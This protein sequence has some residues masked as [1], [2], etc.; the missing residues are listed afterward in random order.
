MKSKMKFGIILCLVFLISNTYSQHV[1]IELSK[2]AGNKSY[3]T[4][5]VG[6]DASGNIY[7]QSRRIHFGKMSLWGKSLTNRGQGIIK[8]VNLDKLS[9][10]PRDHTFLQLI[11]EGP[12]PILVFINELSNELVAYRTN[13]KFELLGSPFVIGDNNEC[14][15]FYYDKRQTGQRTYLTAESCV[16]SDT[17]RLRRVTVNDQNNIYFDYRFTLPVEG[18]VRN[19]TLVETNQNVLIAFENRS[20][21]AESYVFELDNYGRQKQVEIPMERQTLEPADIEIDKSGDEIVLSGQ[22]RNIK[23][24]SLKGLFRANYDNQT[25]RV[26]GI[27]YYYFEQEAIDKYTQRDALH[28]PHPNGEVI[29]ENEEFSIVDRVL[30]SDAG[31]IYFIQRK[32]SQ[33][34]RNV[35]ILSDGPVYYLSFVFH[36]SDLVVV[37]IDAHNSSMWMT[38]IPLYQGFKDGDPGSSVKINYKDGKV[39]ILH[40]GNKEMLLAINTQSDFNITAN[41]STMNSNLIMT[42]ISRNGTPNANQL[43]DLREE[44]FIFN[45]SRVGVDYVNNYFLLFATQRRIF[46]KNKL[47]VYSVS[48]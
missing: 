39:Y 40:T 44:N 15:M 31:I 1:N 23:S 9:N 30:T 17:I 38:N 13:T 48:F 29:E 28:L 42:T 18:G 22:L 11:T 32:T 4:H 41:R 46:G 2:I 19:L 36:Y 12:N 43:L 20:I 27:S 37:K 16:I 34:V 24:K 21:Y 3:G 14:G 8:E 6:T 35:Q 33:L 45:P 25:G 26:S 10:T 7:T 47:K 5:Y